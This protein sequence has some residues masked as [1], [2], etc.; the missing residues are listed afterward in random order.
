MILVVL[1]SKLYDSH[2]HVGKFSGGGVGVWR[3]G[4]GL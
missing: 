1:F 3:W 2:W 4:E